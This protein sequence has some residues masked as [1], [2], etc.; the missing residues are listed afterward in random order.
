MSFDTAPSTFSV[1]APTFNISGTRVH[2]ATTF[3]KGHAL[4]NKS[5]RPAPAG[6]GNWR[7]MQ[8]LGTEWMSDIYEL[9]SRCE[10]KHLA[11]QPEPEA[12][13]AGKT[14][15]ELTPAQQKAATRRAAGQLQDE[16]QAAAPAISQ[17]MD[18]AGADPEIS[19]ETTRCDLFCME[20]CEYALARRFPEPLTPEQATAETI[21]AL[22]DQARKF[23]VESSPNPHACEPLRA[24]TVRT[25][26]RA[27]Q[28]LADIREVLP[29]LQ[30]L[31]G[32]VQISAD[33]RDVQIFRA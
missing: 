11:S 14:F 9:C 31:P 2:I 23:R 1:S 3:Y 22:G 20:I 5:Y 27:C 24:A 21:A 29:A 12:W 7:G 32:I 4:C 18:E 19:A 6:L 33:R 10:S 25:V 8:E 13:P 17:I 28:P 26:V 15:G 30:K 16:L